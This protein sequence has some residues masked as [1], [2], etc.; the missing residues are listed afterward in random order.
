MLCFAR[1]FE[2]NPCYVLQNNLKKTHVT[3][4]NTIWRKP[5]WCFARQFEENPCHVLQ[6]NLKKTRVMFCKTI[7]RKPMRERERSFGKLWLL[8]KYILCWH[9]SQDMQKRNYRLCLRK[10]A[11]LPFHTL[12]MCA[13]CSS[14]HFFLLLCFLLK[15]FSDKTIFIFFN[16]LTYAV[17][18]Y[19]YNFI[20][21]Y[22]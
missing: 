15:F 11:P 14:P 1:Q 17:Y 10:Q 4:C 21:F 8:S 6:D 18:I 13:F 22:L 19:I 9:S 7:W 3:F 2:E 5:M 20:L 16:L 12:L